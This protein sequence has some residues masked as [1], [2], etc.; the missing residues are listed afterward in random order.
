MIGMIPSKRIAT[1]LDIAWIA[2][3]WIRHTFY[4]SFVRILV[5]NCM[6]RSF[7]GIFLRHRVLFPNSLKNQKFDRARIILNKLRNF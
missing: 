6:S 7:Y 1:L 2:E 3:H 5:T 4:K